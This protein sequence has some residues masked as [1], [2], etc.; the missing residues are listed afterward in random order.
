MLNRLD[1]PDCGLR[2]VCW[3]TLNYTYLNE[4]RVEW[5]PLSKSN[6]QING[7]ELSSKNEF[8]FPELLIVYCIKGYFSK[9]MNVIGRASFRHSRAPSDRC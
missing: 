2:A 7:D 4:I 3:T 5:K 9:V 8:E 1:G 6:S